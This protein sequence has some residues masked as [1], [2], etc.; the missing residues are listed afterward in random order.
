MADSILNFKLESST[1]GATFSTLIDPV[2]GGADV[3]T[4]T[5]GLSAPRYYRLTGRT[6]QGLEIPYNVVSRLP[7]DSAPPAVTL[8]SA[9]ASGSTISGTVTLSATA[10]DSTNLQ[11]VEFMIYSLGSWQVGAT[12]LCS[13]TSASVSADWDS[14]TVLNNPI[15]ISVR[16]WDAAGK[17]AWDQNNIIPCTVS[18]VVSDPGTQLWAK[19]IG[20]A[21]AAGSEVWGNATCADSSGNI[22]VAGKFKGTVIFGGTSP[23]M[24]GGTS[25]TAT[26]GYDVFLAKFN[27]SGVMQWVKTYGGTSDDTYQSVAVDNAGGVYVAGFWNGGTNNNPD[28]T[29]GGTAL[30][31][32]S[33]F[34]SSDIVVAKYS[35]TD[36]S[37]LWSKTYGGA[38]GGNYGYGIA[39]YGGNVVFAGSFYITADVGEGSETGYGQLDGFVTKLDGDDG[40]TLWS[41]RFGSTD[42]DYV[43]AVAVD[44]SGNVFVCGYGYA[45]VNFGSGGQTAYGGADILIAKYNGSTGALVWG[46]QIG[47]TQSD[48][49]EGIATDSDG[50]VYATGSFTDALDFGN[51][52]AIT[53]PT[54]AAWTAKF[55]EDGVCQWA[56]KITADPPTAAMAPRSCAVDSNGNV[57][58]HGN[59]SGTVNF[60]DGE[61]TVGI[62][63]PFFVK[64]NSAGAF[65][66]KK[67][68]SS[69]DWCAA[70]SVRM[71]ADRNVIGT[72]YY[73]GT[74]TFGST[75]LPTGG[76]SWIDAYLV[77]YTP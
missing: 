70:W 10:T 74:V 52:K 63:L 26:A 22:Y 40:S 54:S 23:T 45:S 50:N 25:K 73:K 7:A 15:Y 39:C 55:D 34:G 47:G 11:R 27:S 49:A 30:T 19:R 8:T 44:S 31:H 28:V 37:H 69:T 2:P 6:V 1:D 5:P 16:A 64:Y 4:Y 12:V 29:F 18:N 59:S 65:R 67:R 60:G 38:Y 75:Q 66:W 17:V 35:T 72:G 56:N 46:R 41:S 24:A 48:T 51:G 57:V 33:P 36:G 20:A 21:T 32:V 62:A 53:S 43:K 58:I 68:P 76:T 13:G 14:T 9:P 42:A 3:R 61:T 77:K 71:D